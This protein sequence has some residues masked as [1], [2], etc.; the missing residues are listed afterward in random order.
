MIREISYKISLRLTIF[1]AT[2]FAVFC[3][4]E[5]EAQYSGGTNIDNIVA[6]VDNHI[7]LRSDLEAAYMEASSQ[8][9]K[10][11]LNRCDVLRQLVIEKVLLAKAEIDSVVVSDDEVNSNLDRRLQYFMTTYGRE[12]IEEQFGKSVEE[13]RDELRDDIREQLTAQQMQQTITEDVKVTPAEV[14][15]FFSRI[16]QDSLPFYSTEVTVGQIVKLPTVSKDQKDVTRKK[17]LEIRERIL[18]GE[19]FAELAE[20]F[21]EDPG[22]AVKGGELGFMERG[23]LVPEYEAAAL[24]MQPGSIS[25][26]IESEFG[27]HLIQLIERRGNRFNSRHILLKPSSSDLDIKNAEVFLDSLRN[28]ILNDT[29]DFAK[30]AKEHSDD[31]ETSA[32]GGFF[33]SQDGSNRVPTDEIDPVIFFTIDT[34][35]LGDITPPLE[36]RMPDGKQAVRILYYKDRTRP[37]QANLKEDYQKIYNAAL[38]ER[39][40]EALRLWFNEAREEVFIEIDPEFSR[41]NITGSI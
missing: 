22:S 41:C 16:P 12:N 10:A 9:P 31:K 3:T 34:M 2:V 30:A 4:H 15:K 21:S 25:Q 23:Q 33:M 24:Q 11:R 39:K 7:V 13:F 6:K 29:L 1:M 20:E 40:T 19:S 38:N 26:P 32:S 27:F 18:S 28:S 17:L 14:R 36:Y 8:N 5:V 35:Q 37:H